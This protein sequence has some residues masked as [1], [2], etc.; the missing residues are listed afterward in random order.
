MILEVVMIYTMAFVMTL[1]WEEGTSSKAPTLQTADDTS[2]RNTPDNNSVFP[3]ALG[4]VQAIPL[5][6]IANTGWLISGGCF[7]IG[8]IVDLVKVCTDKRGNVWG[9]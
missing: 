9:E 2:K 5:L 3:K 8:R 4:N 1:C 7:G 6:A